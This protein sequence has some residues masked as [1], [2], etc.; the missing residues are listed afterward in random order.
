MGAAVGL[1]TLSLYIP[2]SGSLKGRRAV[3]KS[4]K[5]RI[6]AKFNVSVAEIDDEELWQRAT[7]AVACVSGD[8][9]YANETLN[10]VVDLARG[11]PDAELLDY[12]IETL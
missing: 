10:R 4:L 2:G 7:I 12:A 6:R 1:L 5:D 11:L 3:V 8:G 9:A